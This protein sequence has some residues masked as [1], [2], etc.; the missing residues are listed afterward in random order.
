MVWSSRRLLNLAEAEQTLHRQ[1]GS[2]RVPGSEFFKIELEQ[3]RPAFVEIENRFLDE[4]VEARRRR[5]AN[6]A[7]KKEQERR[8]EIERREQAARAAFRLYETWLVIPA[9]A[10]AKTAVDRMADRWG[11]GTSAGKAGCLISLFVV[12]IWG[13]ELFGAP[14]AIGAVLLMAL[15][16][17]AMDRR[18]TKM[19]AR[20]WRRVKDV[21]PILIWRS[22]E[23][24]EWRLDSSFGA[25]LTNLAATGGS[26]GEAK[27]G[28]GAS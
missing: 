11:V 17:P 13:A 27:A 19:R 5:R 15:L 4:V 12:P 9:V 20:E 14:G 2:S 25:H 24:S 1:L 21:T 6:E 18:Y 23:A 3:A 8:A 16:K 7:R 22:L 26:S 10:N 28:N